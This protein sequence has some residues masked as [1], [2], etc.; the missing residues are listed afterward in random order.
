[1]LEKKI[2]NRRRGPDA[3]VKAIS[4]LSG[5]SWL[6][7][8]GIFI[9]FS[10]AKP[11][12]KTGAAMDTSVLRYAFYLMILQALL[13]G[14]GLAVNTSRLKRRSDKLNLSLIIFGVLS[15]LGIIFY[16]IFV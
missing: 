1:V 6:V 8:L 3:I 9:T 2:K 11:G 13:C 10:M 15:I 4:F 12:I 5:L 14:F 7:I 16:A